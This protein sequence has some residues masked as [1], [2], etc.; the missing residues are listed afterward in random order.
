MV[1]TGNMK[2]DM[3]PPG[4]NA[5]VTWL[6]AQESRSRRRPLLV[7][8]SVIAGEEATVLEALNVVEKQ[9]PQ[10]LLVIAPRKPERFHD[11]ARIIEDAGWRVVRRSSLALIDDSTPVLEYAND[12]RR[13]VLLLDSVGELAAVYWL[14]DAVFIGG[15]LVPSG[16]HNPLELSRSRG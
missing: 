7:A 5:L 3:P 11:A 1:V 4:A 12:R 8:G 14:A 15:S 13:S 16:G 2:Y 9:W 6:E 10:T